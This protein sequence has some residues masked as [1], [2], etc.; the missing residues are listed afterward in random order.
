MSRQSDCWAR[1]LSWLLYPPAKVWHLKSLQSLPKV[2]C[3]PGKIAARQQE[4]YK[5]KPSSLDI[6]TQRFNTDDIWAELT[7]TEAAYR[8]QRTEKKTRSSSLETW[9]VLG[10]GRCLS[11]PFD[12]SLLGIQGLG[13]HSFV[14]FR[15][16]L[17]CTYLPSYGAVY[18]PPAAFGFW[19]LYEDLPADNSVRCT[20]TGWEH[21]K[22]KIEPQLKLVA[23]AYGVLGGWF[24]TRILVIQLSRSGNMGKHRFIEQHSPVRNIAAVVRLPCLRGSQ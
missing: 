5:N 20:I 23:G 22:N 9:G 10:A 11:V 13:T 16:G 8:A 6:M 17:S 12:H 21:F 2:S 15:L 14:Y 1:I 4:V 3:I 7:K 19:H 24:L 18:T